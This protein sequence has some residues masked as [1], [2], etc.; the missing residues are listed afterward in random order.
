LKIHNFN[1][2][3]GFLLLDLSPGYPGG[4]FSTGHFYRIPGISA[5]I[6]CK[7]PGISK[8]NQFSKQLFSPWPKDA[9]F[10]RLSP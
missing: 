9:K 8:I 3:L 10:H 5:I 1:G 4:I 6:R 2:F 7:N